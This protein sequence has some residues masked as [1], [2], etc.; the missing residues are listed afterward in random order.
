MSDWKDPKTIIAIAG[1]V[2][3]AG[4]S[5]CAVMTHLWSRRESRHDVLSGVLRPMTQCVQSL[6]IANNAR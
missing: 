3:A 1:W 4:S 6:M 2:V 5:A